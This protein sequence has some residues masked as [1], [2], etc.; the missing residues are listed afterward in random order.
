MEEI[1]RFDLRNGTHRE[2][3]RVGRGSRKQGAT[4]RYLSRIITILMEAE[5]LC[6]TQIAQ[7]CLS[8]GS[9]R[10]IKDALQWLVSNK[11]II[12]FHNSRPYYK[13]NP[14]FVKLRNGVEDDI[15]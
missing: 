1:K 12:L 10:C 7:G 2:G 11:I 6:I 14:E 8:S 3:G 13:I 5:C 4:T 15:T 9:N